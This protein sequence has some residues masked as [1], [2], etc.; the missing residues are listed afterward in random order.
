MQRIASTLFTAMLLV[1]TACIAQTQGSPDDVLV[2]NQWVK[3][4]RA[5]YELELERVPPESRYEF[6]ASPKRLTAL[7]NQVLVNMTMAKLARNAGLDRDPEIS[8][9]FAHEAD[10]F[11]AQAEMLRIDVD[12]GAYFDAHLNDY[13]PK[14]REVYLLDKAKYHFPEQVSA[15]HI[16]FSTATRGDHAAY[17]LVQETRAKLAAGADFAAL[18][19]QLS[20]DPTAKTNGGALGWFTAAKMD[21]AFSKA[22]FGLKNVGELSEPVQ[23]QFG[24]HVIRLDGRRPGEQKSFEQAS[25]QIMAELRERYVKETREAR[26]EEIRTDPKTKVNQAAIDALVVKLPDIPTPHPSSSAAQ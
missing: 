7:L 15:S 17:A 5:D 24:Y 20:D 3:I 23:S 6:A 18:A 10:R 1:A 11:Y 12:A 19:R 2:E 14:A 21:P 16:L 26:V 22:A 13:L 8:A 4:T 25:R 9:R